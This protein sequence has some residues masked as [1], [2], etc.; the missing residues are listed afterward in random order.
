MAVGPQRPTMKRLQQRLITGYARCPRTE[1][2]VV[3][4][5]ACPAPVACGH[6]APASEERRSS[7]G[8]E[9]RAWNSI[10]SLGRKSL[11]QIKSTTETVRFRG[12]PNEKR[13]SRVVDPI[14]WNYRNWRPTLDTSHPS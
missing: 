1:V 7:R 3:V 11:T 5:F 13:R 6:G 9:A 8:G 14:N 2:G 4:F 12:E 10:R